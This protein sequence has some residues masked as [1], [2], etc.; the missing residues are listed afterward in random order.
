MPMMMDGSASGLRVRPRRIA[1]ET[2]SAAPTRTPRTVRG[3]RSRTVTVSSVVTAARSRRCVDDVG[4]A[5]VPRPCDAG[6]HQRQEQDGEADEAGESHRAAAQSPME[7]SRP[8][9]SR[10]VSSAV[11]KWP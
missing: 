6:E 9:A 8:T 3:T 4:E 1:P 11:A 5:D 10:S 2:P 7:S